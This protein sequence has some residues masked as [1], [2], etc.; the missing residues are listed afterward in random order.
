MSKCKSLAK[1]KV[2]GATI[3]SIR[4]KYDD[5]VQQYKVK[6]KKGTTKYELDYHAKTREL[7]SYGWEKRITSKAG[8]NN[9]IGVEEAKKIALSKVPGAT[10]I[11]VEFDRDDGVP[12]Y[13]VELVKD[14]Y[15]YDIEIH[16]VTGKVLDFDQDFREDI[17]Y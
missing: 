5:G 10:V 11:K 4:L 13:D 16:A 15:E 1:K 2:R 7:L 12:V 14:E 8:N 3:T 17:Y 9:Y 6:M